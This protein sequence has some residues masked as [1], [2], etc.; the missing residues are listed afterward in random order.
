MPPQD[1]DSLKI[2]ITILIYHHLRYD[3]DRV[4]DTAPFNAQ[5]MIRAR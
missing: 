2:S 1:D 3:I 5:A 4:A